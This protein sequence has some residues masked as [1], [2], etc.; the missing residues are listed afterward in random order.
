MEKKTEFKNTDYF[1]HINWDK[2]IVD[3]LVGED[4][5]T[6][7]SVKYAM[8]FAYAQSYFLPEIEKAEEPHIKANLM[9]IMQYF[10]AKFS[11]HHALFYK[12]DVDFKK[13]ESEYIGKD[14][15]IKLIR[16]KFGKTEQSNLPLKQLKMLESVFAKNT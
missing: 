12:N 7:R 15:P 14:H 6:K 2:E 10:Y 11:Y 8:I 5:Q 4:A 9:R 16:K 1:T 3:K 13:V